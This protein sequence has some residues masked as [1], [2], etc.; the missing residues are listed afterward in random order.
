MPEVPWKVKRRKK[1]SKREVGWG[2][3]LGRSKEMQKVSSPPPPVTPV[4]PSVGGH[5]G[6]TS[7]AGG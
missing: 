6:T 7:K 3:E 2:W 4:P 1:T 5:V